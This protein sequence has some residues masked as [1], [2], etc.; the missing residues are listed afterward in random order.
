[1]GM[2]TLTG[3]WAVLFIGVIALAMIRKFYT[4]SEDDSIHLHGG[5]MKVISHQKS[6]ATRLDQIDRWGK[7]LT[8]I[9]VVYGLALVARVIYLGWV[10]SAQIH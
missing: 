2:Y 8:A 7:V 6:L 3:V 1:M 4:G 10:E 9:V 5:D